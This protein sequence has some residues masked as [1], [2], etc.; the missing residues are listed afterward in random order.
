MW[1]KINI[2]NNSTYS[3]SDKGIIRNDVSGKV[4]KNCYWKQRTSKNKR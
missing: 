4:L 3:I 1:K 2:E